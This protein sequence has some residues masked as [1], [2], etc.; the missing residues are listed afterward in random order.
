MSGGEAV[1]APGEHPEGFTL[2][3]RPAGYPSVGEQGTNRTAA[4][5]ADGLARMAAAVAIRVAAGLADGTVA[6]RPRAPAGRAQPA[7]RA[8]RRARYRGRRRAPLPRWRVVGGRRVPRG[9]GV[10]CPVGLPHH[11][12]AAGR[13]DEIVDDRARGVLGPARAAAVAGAVL[14]SRRDRALLRG[15]GVGAGDSGP[16]GR[17]DIGADLLQQLA[18]D[19]GRDELLRGD[20]AGVAAR[21]HLVAGDRGAVLPGVADRARRCPVAR[22]SRHPT[23]R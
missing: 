13:V 19:R 11:L 16:E 18:S 6:G 12:A 8:R 14:P 17:R 15:G 1:R 23:R 10:L 3:L 9:R 2:A 5:G 7:R 20:G 22:D 21:A 4:V